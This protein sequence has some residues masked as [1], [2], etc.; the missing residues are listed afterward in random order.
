M[1]YT[2][3]DI[4]G[5]AGENSNNGGIHI[6]SVSAKEERGIRELEDKVIEMFL[7]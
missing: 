4:Y 3:N 7:I 6:I 5:P 2:V 1:R